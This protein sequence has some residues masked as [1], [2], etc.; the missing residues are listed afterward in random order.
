MFRGHVTI[1]VLTYPIALVP[2]AAW[3]SYRE[4][5]AINQ[6]GQVWRELLICFALCI[7][8]AM[9]PDIDVKSKSQRII[10][11]I[12]VPAD[13]ILILFHYYREAAIIGF[14]G[15]LPNILK[16]RG[17]LHSWSAALILPSPLLIIPI[18]F[19]GNLNFYQLGISYYI[20]AVFGYMS[21]LIADRKG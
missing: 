11:S 15:I 21:H 17:Q 20:A 4:N 1:G 12:L 10:Y 19:T 3:I 7:L 6:L 16:H 13:L 14:F 5:F 9:F 2:I 18:I 8:G